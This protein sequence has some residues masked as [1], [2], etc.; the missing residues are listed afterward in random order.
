[1]SCLK[2]VVVGGGG[3]GGGGG[4]RK[5]VYIARSVLGRKYGALF[6][7]YDLDVVH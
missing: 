1:M 3:E 2:V 7:E 6:R 5:R 4:R